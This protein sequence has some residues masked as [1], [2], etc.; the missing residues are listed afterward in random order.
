MENNN[1][2]LFVDEII[3]LVKN[4]EIYSNLVKNNLELGKFFSNHEYVKSLNNF[5]NSHEN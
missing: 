1:I 2:E 4:K 3:K 5:Y